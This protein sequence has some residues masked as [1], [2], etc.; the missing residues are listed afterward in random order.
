MFDSLDDWICCWQW[1]QRRSWPE[2]C[3]VGSYYFTALDSVIQDILLSNCCGS[4]GFPVNVW[5]TCADLLRSATLHIKTPQF[6]TA[7]LLID[8]IV[9]AIV[10]DTFSFLTDVS[11][12]QEFAKYREWGKFAASVGH[13]KAKGFQ[14]PGGLRPPD[15]G[16]CPWTPL[17][18]DAPPPNPRYIG[19]R[20]AFAIRVRIA[21]FDWRRPCLHPVSVSPH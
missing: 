17:G 12:I 20:S 3:W 15:Q 7:V 6:Q 9:H 1:R 8:S 19:S 4:V 10:D 18:A 14:L 13:Q 21:F 16:L 2:Q 5:A 11:Q